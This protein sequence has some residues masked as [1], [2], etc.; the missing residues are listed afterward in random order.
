[1]LHL[2]FFQWTILDTS[3][4]FLRRRGELGH[5]EYRLAGLSTIRNGSIENLLN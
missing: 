1:M 5:D 2:G 3:R 4:T